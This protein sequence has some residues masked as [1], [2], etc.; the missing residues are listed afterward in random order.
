MATKPAVKTVLDEHTNA[1]AGCVVIQWSGLTKATDDDGAPVEFG[2]FADRSVQVTGT[3]GTGGSV[4]I[5]GSN[6]GTNYAVLTDPQGNAIEKDAASIEIVSERPLY[7]RPRITAGDG[8]TAINVIL[9][10]RRGR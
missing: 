6:D 5:E 8:T 10:M 7:V 4:R 1:S 9:L 2:A 3:F